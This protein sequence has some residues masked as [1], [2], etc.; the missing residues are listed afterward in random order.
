VVPAVHAV[1]D[2][3]A[4]FAERVRNGNWKGHTGNASATW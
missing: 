4:G 3:M 2:K 1:L